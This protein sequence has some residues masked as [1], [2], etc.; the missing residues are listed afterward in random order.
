MDSFFHNTAFTYFDV[1]STVSCSTT[2][3]IVYLHDIYP[4]VRV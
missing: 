4:Y 3:A 2:R 1:V